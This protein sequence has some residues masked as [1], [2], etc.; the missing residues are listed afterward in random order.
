MKAGIFVVAELAEPVRGKILEVQRWA[1]PRL[2]AGTPPHITMAGSS[3]V[4]PLPLGTSVE[5][6]RDR[7]EPITRETPPIT[8]RF[9]RPHRFM[10][11]DIIVLPLDPHGPLRTLHER[12]AATGLPFE[13]ARF[14][15]SPHATLSFYPRMSA[16]MLQRLL[17]VRI[18]D[19]VVI[20]ALQFYSTPHPQPSA[21]VLELRLEGESITRL[22][23][24][25]P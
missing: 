6:L 22:P 19:D 20:S 8:M 11:T 10:Q 17:A 2:A 5:L 23:A 14:Q 3:G 21:R 16:E 1:D 15:F 18:E 7:V 24:S 4:G 13:R 12:M 25:P 9:E